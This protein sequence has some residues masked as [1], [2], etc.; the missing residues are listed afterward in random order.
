MGLRDLRGFQ[1]SSSIW[2]GLHLV[3]EG[4]VLRVQSTCS[5]PQSSDRLS[6]FKRLPQASSVTSF[7]KNC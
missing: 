1:A 6:Y 4:K 5:L 3:S 2:E 7:I